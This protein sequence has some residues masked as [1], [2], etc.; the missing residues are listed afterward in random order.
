MRDPARIDRILALLREVWIGAPDQRIGQLINN[1]H[2]MSGL[3]SGVPMF[4]VEDDVIEDGL[5]TWIAGRR[6]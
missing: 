5:S 3:S 4:H 2:S 6:T 1:A